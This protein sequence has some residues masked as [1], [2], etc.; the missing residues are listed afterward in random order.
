[1]TC[2]Y[3]CSHEAC[4]DQHLLERSE[5]ALGCGA[6]IGGDPHVELPDGPAHLD[7]VTALEDEL[8]REAT[9]AMTRETAV[10]GLTA[11]A[12]A[13]TLTLLEVTR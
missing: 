2:S 6:Q 10:V 1:M 13:L 4:I 9:A 7:C 11:A 5:C 12:V 8:A 3:R